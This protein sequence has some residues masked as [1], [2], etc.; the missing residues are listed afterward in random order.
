VVWGSLGK[1]KHF[2]PLV[3]RNRILKRLFDTVSEA[4]MD[5]MIG[6]L[7]NLLSSPCV[8]NEIL[9]DLGKAHKHLYISAV[10]FDKFIMLWIREHQKDVHFVTRAMPIIDKLRSYF[11]MA[12]ERKVLDFCHMLKASQ[13]LSSKFQGVKEHKMKSLCAATYKYLETAEKDTLS[14]NIWIWPPCCISICR[15]LMT[16]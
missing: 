7:N 12:D 1:V 13:V 10:E 14:D 4:Q 16:N 9:L 5:R 6:V 11:V 3:Q 8:K 15:W 2:F